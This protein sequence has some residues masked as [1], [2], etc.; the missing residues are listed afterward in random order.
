MG[1]TG[2]K[3]KKRHSRIGHRERN[4]QADSRTPFYVS[5]KGLRGNKMCR[6]GEL[7]GT[8]TRYRPTIKEGDACCSPTF[9]R[10]GEPGGLESMNQTSAL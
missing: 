5:A 4:R 2:G 8:G 7:G 6:P 3:T 10:Q 1:Q 9:V